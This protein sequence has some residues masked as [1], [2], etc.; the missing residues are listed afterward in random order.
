MRVFDVYR[1]NK[2]M[3]PQK[4]TFCEKCDPKDCVILII[5]TQGMQQGIAGLAVHYHCFLF[6]IYLRF[7]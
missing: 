6:E 3:F 7:I 4:R 5:V 2:I 1:P